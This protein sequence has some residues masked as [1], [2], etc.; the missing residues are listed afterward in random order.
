[1]EIRS[2]NRL[3][4]LAR[5]ATM[6]TR[7]GVGALFLDADLGAQKERNVAAQRLGTR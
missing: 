1:M 6:N 7:E 5:Y 2:E 3:I 4:S